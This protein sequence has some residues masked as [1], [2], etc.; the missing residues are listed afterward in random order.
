M[1]VKRGGLTG[2]A[3]LAGPRLA[4]LRTLAWEVAHVPAHRW[5]TMTDRTPPASLASPATTKGAPVVLLPGIY[6]P[7]R[8]LLPLAR[9]LHEAGHPV[10]VVPELGFNRT[11]LDEAVEI[12]VA[13]LTSADVRGGVLVGH[14]KGGLIG[15]ALLLDERVAWRLRGLVSLCTPWQGARWSFRLLGRTPLALFARTGRELSGLASSEGVDARITS[16]QPAWDQFIPEPVAP[17]GARGIVLSVSGHLRP[18]LEPGVHEIV[19][20][21]VARLASSGGESDWLAEEGST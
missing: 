1:G 20:D 4:A 13:A 14:S 12:A 15:K 10:I 17:A 9:A 11:G 3:G 21:E 5:M 8:Y 6:E 2:L 7:W 18:L 19:V 16:L